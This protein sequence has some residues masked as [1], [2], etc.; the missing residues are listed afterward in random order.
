MWTVLHSVVIVITFITTEKSFK[1][2]DNE[3]II[4][5]FA[6]VPTYMFTWV[7]KK[8]SQNVCVFTNVYVCI[9]RHV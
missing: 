7:K 9:I 5:V 1:R 2:H 4:F 8:L 6:L 3:I